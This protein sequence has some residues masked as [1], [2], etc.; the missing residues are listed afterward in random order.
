MI[1][2][3]S[4]S[5]CLAAC[6]MWP[7]S[8]SAQWRPSAADSPQEPAQPD[9]A[10]IVLGQ[11]PDVPI[12]LA[13][14]YAPQSGVDSYGD[15]S[16]FA[17]P[18]YQTQALPWEREGNSPIRRF[19]K[20]VAGNTYFRVEYLNWNIDDVGAQAVGANTALVDDVREP[21]Q[22]ANF[23]PISMVANADLPASQ[24]LIVP[25]LEPISFNRVSGVRATWEIPLQFGRVEFSGFALENAH[26]SI[27]DPSFGPVRGTRTLTIPEF[28]GSP[29]VLAN[30][31]TVPAPG[32]NATSGG[33]VQVLA[34]PIGNA[35]G[36]PTNIPAGSLLPLSAD[37]NIP[38]GNPPFAQ[39]FRPSVLGINLNPQIVGLFGQIIRVPLPNGPSGRSFFGQF[40]VNALT[41]VNQIAT[42]DSNLQNLFA[43]LQ[44]GDI[45]G[46][47]PPGSGI[48]FIR[49]GTQ[50]TPLQGNFSPTFAIA[51]VDDGVPP[52]GSRN[53]V[54]QFP[55]R[56][57]GGPATIFVRDPTLDGDPTNPNLGLDP[58]TGLLAPIPVGTPNFIV[59]GSILLPDVF[60]PAGITLPAGT[61]LRTN[62]TGFAA[63]P[64][65]TTGQIGTSFLIFDG[66]YAADYHSEIWGSEAKLIF[67]IGPNANGFTLN[68]LVGFRY[69]SFDEQFRQVGLSSFSVLSLNL[70]SAVVVFP[71]PLRAAE[72]D[73]KVQNDLYGLQIGASAEYNN[74]YVTLGVDPRISFGVNHYEA[75]VTTNQL[76]SVF[77]PRVT[78]RQDDTTFAPVFDVSMYGQVHLTPN[79]S[80]HAGYNFTYLFRVT[81]PAENIV[82]NDNGPFAPPGVVVD[83]K[84]QDA[85]IQGLTVGG[86]FRFRDLKFR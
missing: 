63:M 36:L 33:L 82:Y 39:G 49:S 42:F 81:R 34:T 16:G 40:P 70:N 11:S 8:L 59:P 35:V 15:G 73:S 32:Y 84:T 50:N 27:L 45:N 26:D 61:V 4:L 60:S 83:S 66:G 1:A 37:G 52:T 67:D 5:A 2:R 30:T 43:L 44:A 78:T 56:F 10:Q 3:I 46:T 69:M 20:E 54:P 57:P 79:F 47:L 72:I 7:S 77:D 28:Q 9:P 74:K 48:L 86:E 51:N 12:Q 13:G 29:F 6:V 55:N 53:P 68:P 85:H 75:E 18:I 19:F 14:G 80:L 25:D 21:I 76:R 41:G 65:L 38:P 71:E 23:F 58:N 31:L 64:L 24:T 62:E 17:A 22:G